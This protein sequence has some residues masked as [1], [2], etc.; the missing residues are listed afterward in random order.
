M[1]YI[2]TESRLDTII[3]EYLIEIFDVKIFS[4]NF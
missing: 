2:I 3:T 4:V 1:K